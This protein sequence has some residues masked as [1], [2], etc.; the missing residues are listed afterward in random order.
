MSKILN[1]IKQEAIRQYEELTMIPSENHVSKNVQA[2]VGSVLMNK[3]SEGLVGK[4]YYQGNKY[5]DEMET[6]VLDLAKKVF[7]V[8]D[9]YGV[10]VQAISGSVANLAA[11]TGT[12]EIGSKILS[13]HLFDGGHLSHGWKLPEGRKVSLTSKIFDSYFYHVDATT[14]QFDYDE[15]EKQAKEVQPKMII[16]G[17]TAYPREID[18][19]RMSKIA[20]S[21]GAL[22]LADVAHEAG[23]IAG[24]ANNSP[25]GFADIITM[26]SRK[27]LRGPI[28]ALI[29][30]KNDLMSGIQSAL[31]PGLQG[32]PM[33]HS[34][35]GIGVALEE[36]LEASFTEYAHQVVTNAQ[37][38]A[39]ELTKRGYYLLS[40]GTDKHLILIDLR[41]KNLT[42][43][44]VATALEAAGIIVNKNTVPN[45][46][47]KPWNPSGIRL[48]TPAL[49]TRGMKEPEMIKIAAW[50][51]EASMN[52]GNPEILEKIRLE[53]K[54]FAKDFPLP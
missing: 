30:A 53:I 45:D 19:E 29:F 25:F 54:E 18:Y 34:I 41:N 33:N 7:K 15:I 16:S 37:V 43:N 8:S 13:M 40:G 38:L 26:T 51:D 35:A 46:T 50:I 17:G 2:A 4:R 20:K 36:A 23:L 44:M 12:L 6:Y 48:G 3:Y 31:F 1:L 22:Y 32:G 27:T 9:D 11:L 28:G 49:T 10:I 14:E 24:G 21:V 5:I 42:G 47:G 39:T 52:K